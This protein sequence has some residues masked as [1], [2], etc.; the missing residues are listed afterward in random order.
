MYSVSQHHRP[1]MV[2]RQHL[3]ASAAGSCTSGCPGAG[4]AAAVA[5]AL[6]NFIGQVGGILVCLCGSVTYHTLM[7]HQQKY[8][9]WL[10]VDVSS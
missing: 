4:L 1:A 5:G 9:S 8:R 10:A 6:H 3:D 7:A 2:C